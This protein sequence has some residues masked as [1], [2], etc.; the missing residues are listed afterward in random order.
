M[1]LNLEDRSMETNYRIKLPNNCVIE[2]PISYK[3]VPITLG[4]TTFSV[5]LIQ[6]D[7][8]DFDIILEMNWLYIYG[9]KIECEDLKVILKDKKGEKYV[10]MGRERKNIVP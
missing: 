9:A 7:L 2:C 8:S 5:N 4:G 10:S 6:F 1:Q 3:L